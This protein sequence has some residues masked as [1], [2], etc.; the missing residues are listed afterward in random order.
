MDIGCYHAALWFRESSGRIGYI[1][2][3]VLCL[4]EIWYFLHFHLNRMHGWSVAPVH[5]T[6][7]LA[8]A[9]SHRGKGTSLSMAINHESYIIFHGENSELVIPVVLTRIGFLLSCTLI[10]AAQLLGYSLARFIPGP[11]KGCEALNQRE[12]LH[13]SSGTLLTMSRDCQEMAM[14]V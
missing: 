10:L 6:E 5:Y 12:R 8:H 11:G 4:S 13:V 7:E 3:L 1:P 9:G 2:S 14:S